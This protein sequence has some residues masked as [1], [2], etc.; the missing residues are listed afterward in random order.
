MQSVIR[1]LQIKPISNRPSLSCNYVNY[2]AS[3]AQDTALE[4]IATL[5]TV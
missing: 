1:A 4:D 3:L 2:M 5:E